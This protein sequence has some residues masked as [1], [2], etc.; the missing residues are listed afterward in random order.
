MLASSTASENASRPVVLTSRMRAGR[1]IRATSAT[2]AST[3]VTRRERA[4]RRS[5]P[6]RRVAPEQHR[7][8]HQEHDHGEV[9]QQEHADH[10]LPV[11]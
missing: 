2:P 8:E 3:A 9:L 1:T 11:R 4:G 6:E 7:R 10:Q 5:A